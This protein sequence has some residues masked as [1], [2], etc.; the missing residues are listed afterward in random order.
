MCGRYNEK[1]F[2]KK[3]LEKAKK[4]KKKKLHVDYLFW[5]G[6]FA[7]SFPFIHNTNMLLAIGDFIPFHKIEMDW[8]QN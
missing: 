8:Y 1:F 6:H 2:F 7:I 4:K 3:I 5:T